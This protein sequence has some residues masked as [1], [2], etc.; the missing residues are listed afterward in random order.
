MK[1][2][3]EVTAI[4]IAEVFAVITKFCPLDLFEAIRRYEVSEAFWQTTFAHN[5]IH[6]F[7]GL[8]DNTDDVTE[9]VTAG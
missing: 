5:P 3:H 2:Q 6:P 8:K 7:Q 9:N 1:H 4:S